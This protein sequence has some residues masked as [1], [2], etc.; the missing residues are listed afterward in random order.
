MIEELEQA[1]KKLTKIKTLLAELRGARARLRN[2]ET[3]LKAGSKWTVS[4]SFGPKNRYGE[5]VKVPYSEEGYYCTN[6]EVPAAQVIQSLSYRCRDL[7][8]ELRKLG[9]PEEIIAKGNL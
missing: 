7:A 9:V 1:E 3:Y 8:Y 2:A 5:D 6:F 4:L